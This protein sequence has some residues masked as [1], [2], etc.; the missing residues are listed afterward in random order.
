MLVQRPHT[1]SPFCSTLSTDQELLAGVPTLQ[2]SYSVQSR[3]ALLR[4]LRFL[5][6]RNSSAAANTVKDVLRNGMP[7]YMCCFKLYIR[8]A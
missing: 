1:F 5:H 8:Q 7:A 4:I 3:Q 6:V 2:H